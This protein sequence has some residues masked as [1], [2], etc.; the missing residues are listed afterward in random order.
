MEIA[1]F[2]VKCNKCGTLF[3][4]PLL[5]DF[6]YGE[7]IARSENGAVVAYLN[8]FEELSFNEIS[9]LFDKLFE[10]YGID[11]YKSSCFRFVVGKCSDRIEGQEMRMD[12][13]P[14][15]PE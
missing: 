7:F 13:D 15:C 1:L 8:A 6:S 5:S 9:S 10:K 14:I 12:L 11:L 3:D 2:E 4:T